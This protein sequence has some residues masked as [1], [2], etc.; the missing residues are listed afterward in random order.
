M[1]EEYNGCS[2]IIQNK[3]TRALYSHFCSCA[4]NLAVVGSCSLVVVQNLFSVMNKANKFFDNHPKHQYA[5]NKCSSLKVKSLR[6]TR[7]VQCLMA[8]FS[9][10]ILLLMTHQD[11]HM[12]LS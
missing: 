7:W 9:V 2:A 10:S 8:M 12:M 1:A 3:H 5:L 6:K 4:L 11:G